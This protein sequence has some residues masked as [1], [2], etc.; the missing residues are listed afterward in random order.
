MI[1][2][3]HNYTSLSH[4]PI[5]PLLAGAANSSTVDDAREGFLIELATFQLLLKKSVMI[6]D[7]ETRQV[8]QYQRE[9]ERIGTA[10]FNLLQV[11]CLH[12]S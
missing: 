2:R 9:R 11:A 4:T 3:F 8:E 5:V 12:S 1:K 6:C 7:A 10:A